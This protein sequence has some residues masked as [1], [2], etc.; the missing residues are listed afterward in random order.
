MKWV[1][2]WIC[3]C[4]ADLQVVYMGYQEDHVREV[5]RVIFQDHRVNKSGSYMIAKMDLDTLKHQPL[6]LWETPDGQ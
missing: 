3:A 2:I 5:A 1:I 6:V 4:N